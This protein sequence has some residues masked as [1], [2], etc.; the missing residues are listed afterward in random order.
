MKNLIAGLTAA[1]LTVPLA[2]GPALA[3]KFRVVVQMEQPIEEIVGE[4]VLYFGEA[5]ARAYDGPA[6]Q[7]LGSPTDETGR[8]LTGDAGAVS[9]AAIAATAAGGSALKAP[10]DLNTGREV[11]YDYVDGERLLLDHVSQR[12]SVSKL[13][14]AKT[15]P[16]ASILGGAPDGA[17]QDQTQALGAMFAQFSAPRVD[18]KHKVTLRDTGETSTVEINEVKVP[19]ER[20]IMSLMGGDVGEVWI[21]DPSALENGDDFLEAIKRVPLDASNRANDP[22]GLF[23][24][25][26]FDP[27]GGIPIRIDTYAAEDFSL[28]D[29]AAR[30][31]DYRLEVETIETGDEFKV[32]FAASIPPEE[33]EAYREFA[34]S[35]P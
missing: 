23:R 6:K 17:S 27:A 14:K 19:I 8:L 13:A 10:L 33:Y 29:G 28:G 30:Q 26:A 34:S 4:G 12:R 25:I 9:G 11:L 5:G 18:P 35:G 32:E 3:G 24:Q 7:Y 1:A 21:A 2:G 16:G 20:K 31:T 22:L 15:N